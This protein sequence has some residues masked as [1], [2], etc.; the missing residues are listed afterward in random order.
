MANIAGG[1]EKE[2]CMRKFLIGLIVGLIAFPVLAVAYLLSG[3]APVGVTDHP[4]PLERYIAGEVLEKGI[5]R[6]APTREL[7]SFSSAEIAAGAK[8]YHEVCGG[9]HG[10]LEAN[11]RPE[12]KMYPP[13]PKLLTPD[14]YVTDDPVGATFW[15][16][17]NG[18]RMTGMPS[19]G[20]VL[21]DDQMWQIAALLA[22]ADKLPSEVMDVL[23][24]PL[25]PPASPSASEKPGSARGAKPEGK[26]APKH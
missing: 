2:Q 17:K 4:L 10:L 26:A 12:P 11:N 1:H 19:F 9:C 5:E 7:S 3:Y 18:L 8:S 25:F 14:G 21:Q 22:S 23:K 24:Q 6:R 13:P 15:T 20:G 16:I